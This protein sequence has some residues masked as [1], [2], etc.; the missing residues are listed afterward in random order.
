MFEEC[1]GPLVCLSFHTSVISISVFSLSTLSCSVLSGLLAS[2]SSVNKQPLSPGCSTGPE[3]SVCR[4]EVAS[5]S[6][7][8]PC[9]VPNPSSI[10]TPSSHQMSLDKA[11]S[12]CIVGNWLSSSSLVTSSVIFSTRL[13]SSPS[14]HVSVSHV[15]M[16]M[17]SVFMVTHRDMLCCPASI[18]LRAWGTW[19]H[20]PSVNLTPTMLFNGQTIADSKCDVET[21]SNLKHLPQTPA[22]TFTCAVVGD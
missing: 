22:N 7:P 20:I 3:S 18:L 13:S 5:S 15:G 17:S 14:L 2:Q 1:S 9:S 19:K 6:D 4:Q 21:L 11:A 12:L 8:N 10:L 16:I